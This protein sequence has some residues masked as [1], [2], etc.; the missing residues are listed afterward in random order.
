MAGLEDNTLRMVLVGK[1]GSGK[2]ATGNSILGR[3]AFTSKIA[4]QAVTKKCQRVIE[5]W[6]GRKLF[7]VDTPG[8]FDTKETLKT[9]CKR[10]TECAL[11]S[12]P[13]PHAIIL[14]LQLGRYTAEEQKT[15]ALI[16]NLFGEKAMKHMIIL[17]TRKDELGD[18]TLHEFIEASGVNLQSMIK[19]C[20]NHCCAF[21]NRSRDEAEKE[22]QLQ[23]LVKLI[24]E[25]VQENGGAHFSD[26]IYQ[27]IGEKLQCQEKALKEIYA[28]Q[29]QKEIKLLEEQ[30]AKGKISEQERMEKKKSRMEYYNESIENIREEAERNIFKDSVN[31]I[32]NSYSKVWN[33]F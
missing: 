22:A 8:L 19:E 23:E 27:N 3:E 33:L 5:N 32:W 11:L 31:W 6:K 25:V 28:D 21:N 30:L 2:S 17:F 7:V 15:V 9:T 1:T 10:I 29:L 4:A 16:K 14:V 24:E 26:A 18:Q 20:G 12:Y 13:G